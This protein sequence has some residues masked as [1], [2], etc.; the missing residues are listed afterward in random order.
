MI[1]ALYDAAEPE[2][3]RR[4]ERERYARSRIF[5]MQAEA[6]A[7][8]ESAVSGLIGEKGARLDAERSLVSRRVI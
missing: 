4:R 6:R 2:E 8:Q 7:S 5:R 1:D 3:T